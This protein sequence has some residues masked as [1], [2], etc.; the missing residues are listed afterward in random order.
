MSEKSSRD[1]SK[2]K[3]LHLDESVEVLEIER[4]ATGRD[5][6]LRVLYKARAGPKTYYFKITTKGLT[7]VWQQRFLF[8][9]SEI[10]RQAT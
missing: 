4:S 1:I 5:R 10:A 7:L 6:L 8:E 2:Q 9:V 3:T